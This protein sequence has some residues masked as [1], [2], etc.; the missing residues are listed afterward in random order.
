V[1]ALTTGRVLVA[2]E[3]TLFALG[4]DGD[5]EVIM[6]TTAQDPFLTLASDGQT[7]WVL[8]RYGVFRTGRRPARRAAIPDRA[9]RL[10]VGL[11]T[12]QRSVIRHL[13]I[14]RPEDTRLADRWYAHFLPKVMVRVKGVVTHDNSIAYDA[15]FPVRYL[16][17]S[18]TS[19]DQCC[20]GAFLEPTE[21]ATITL[22]WDLAKLIAGKGNASPPL[23]WIEQ[24]LRP[25]RGQVLDE[26]R[27]RYRDAAWLVRELQRPPVDEMAA[28]TLQLRL[29]EHASYLEAMAGREVVSLYRME[30]P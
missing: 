30:E 24:G 19:A 18:A 3:H 26:V 6:R 9:P 27:W 5:Q 12:V 10:R 7:A 17:A 1:A 23:S 21:G 29:E 11:D 8:T 28:L 20:G 15:T 14:G 16:L 2:T 25:I 4:A 13:G 22:T